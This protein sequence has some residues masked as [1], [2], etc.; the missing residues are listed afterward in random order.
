MSLPF[1]RCN[2]TECIY[3]RSRHR[4]VFGQC[5][6]APLRRGPYCCPYPCPAHSRVVW[7]ARQTGQS[8]SITSTSNSSLPSYYTFI[9]SFSISLWRL[10]ISLKSLFLHLVKSSAYSCGEY[11]FKNALRV[12][13]GMFLLLSFSHLFICSR[14]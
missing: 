4:A 13:W 14:F 5:Q 1:R 3:H 6:C 7:W 12:E 11:I 8:N 2:P 9:K 10:N